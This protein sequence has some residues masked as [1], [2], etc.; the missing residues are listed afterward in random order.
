MS[1]AQIT[2]LAPIFLPWVTAVVG[3]V[4]AFVQWRKKRKSEAE[5]KLI[6]RR[7]EAPYLVPSDNHFDRLFIA[8]SDHEARFADKEAVLNIFRDE[9]LTNTPAGTPIFLVVENQGKAARRVSVFLDGQEIQLRDEPR[10]EFASGL[11]FLQYA[12]DPKRHGQQQKLVIA[13]ETP[14]GVQDRH[15]YTMKHGFRSLR[16]QDPT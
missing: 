2:K 10:L 1:I 3:W 6:R 7:G 16:R 9:I 12:Y 4:T 14:S 13:F 8:A 15:I 5:L 11:T